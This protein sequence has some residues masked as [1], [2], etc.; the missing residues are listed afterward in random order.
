MVS[1]SGAVLH[2]REAF[3][4]VWAVLLVFVSAVSSPSCSCSA[5][6]GPVLFVLSLLSCSC[7]SRF[8]PSSRV[9]VRAMG[10]FMLWRRQI[11]NV[12]QKMLHPIVVR[13]LNG[14]DAFF[15]MRRIIQ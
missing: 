1:S 11:E 10:P 9:R 15:K 6:P 7:S 4:S 13:P 12:S 3:V 8:L 2:L 5:L 14:C